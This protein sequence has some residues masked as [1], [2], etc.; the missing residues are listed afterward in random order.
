MRAAPALALFLVGLSGHGLIAFLLGFNVLLGHGAVRA[1]L[2]GV[3]ALQRHIAA[4][5]LDGRGGRLVL[6]ARSRSILVL[7]RYVRGSL[8]MRICIAARQS[9]VR[10]R[11][12]RRGSLA[13]G[14]CF[15]RGG[16]TVLWRGLETARL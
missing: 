9:G 16:G 12:V 11:C 3:A 5:L 6:L 15:Q 4:V 7:L 10:L 2:V 14:R 1:G 13:V 8:V